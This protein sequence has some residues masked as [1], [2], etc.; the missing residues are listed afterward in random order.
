VATGFRYARL[1][2]WKLLAAYTAISISAL[3][4][5]AAGI[6]LW[7]VLV[8]PSSVL[9]AFV[10]SQLM[11]ILWLSAR[12]WQRAVAAVFYLR[13]MLIAPGYARSMVADAT[14]ISGRPIVPVAT[15]PGA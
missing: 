15:V 6:W 12:M 7:H 13:E 11:L 1:F 10:I 2:W 9:G 8:P 4:V 5:L 3:L 14:P